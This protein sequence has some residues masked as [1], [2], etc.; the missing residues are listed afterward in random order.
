MFNDTWTNNIIS[1]EQLGPGILLLQ[2][3]YT[4]LNTETS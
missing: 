1:F 4:D 2:L 3:Y